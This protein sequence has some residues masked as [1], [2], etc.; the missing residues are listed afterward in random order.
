MARFPSFRRAWRYALRSVF[1]LLILPLLGGAA[2]VPPSVGGRLTPLLAGDLAAPLSGSLAFISQGNV[3]LLASDG[4]RQITSSGEAEAVRWSPGGGYLSV[5]GAGSAA[6]FRANGAPTNLMTGIWNQDDTA[7]ASADASGNVLVQSTQDGTTQTLLTAPAGSRFAPAAWS[8]D[9]G[10]LLLDRTSR[11]EDGLPSAEDVWM[12]GRDGSG[13]QQ[14][15]P[16]GAVWPRAL[17]WS[18]DGRWITAWLGPAEACA[19]CRADGQPFEIVRPDGSR[20]Q[21]PGVLLRPEWLAWSPDSSR[22]VAAL[23][24][25]RET[26][27][28]KKLGLIDPVTGVVQPGGTGAVQI[29]PAW[30]PDGSSLAYTAAPALPG[31]IFTNLDPAHGYPDPVLGH[32]AV[33]VLNPATGE[34]VAVDSPEHAAAESP[35]W[36]GAQTLL[37][38]HWRLAADASVG[39]HAQLWSIDLA[40]GRRTLLVSDLGAASPPPNYYGEFGWAHLFSWH[41]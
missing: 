30:S 28:D 21:T 20:S 33:R 24:P 2:A 32:R 3:W 19:S 36:A 17:G 25:G 38:V 37:S 8:P 4:T 29:Q 12:I 9:G 18:P 41:Q 27:R 14:V 15:L 39:P 23:G 34:D 6:V 5:I 35:V 16:A 11:G 13:L 7:V 1:A 26:Y 10:Q 31:A 22:L 40:S